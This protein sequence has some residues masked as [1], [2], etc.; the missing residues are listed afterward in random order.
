MFPGPDA[1]VVIEGSQLTVAVIST[2]VPAIIYH[3]IA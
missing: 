2:G 3:F 1:E